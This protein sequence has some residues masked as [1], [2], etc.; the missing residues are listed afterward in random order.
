MEKSKRKHS[1]DPLHIIKAHPISKVSYSF[2]LLMSITIFVFSVYLLGIGQA[3]LE[4]IGSII[5]LFIFSGWVMQYSWSRIRESVW[6]YEAGIE[7]RIGNRRLFA[8]WD[9]LIEIRWHSRGREGFIGLQSDIPL[10]AQGS[11]NIIER[12]LP[13]QWGRYTIRIPEM[14]GVKTEIDGCWGG[15]RI[16]FE[17]L[18]QV[19]FGQILHDYAPHLF[20]EQAKR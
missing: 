12:L 7:H 13:V 8:L 14:H 2:S 3:S 5:T 18:R 9:N 19:K 1:D 16:D 4:V 20:D 17:Q 6:I 11:I 10:V 15:R